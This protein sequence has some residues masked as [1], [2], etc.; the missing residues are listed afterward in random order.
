MTKNFASLLQIEN[1]RELIEYICPN[2]RI[3]VWALIRVSFMRTIMSDW[4]FNSVPMWS[5][6]ENLNYMKMAKNVVIS[7]IHNYGYQI[8]YERKIL[9]Q[10][11]GIGNYTKNGIVHD[12]LAGYFAEILPKQTLVYQDKPKENFQDKYSFNPV[13][14]N[15]P[16]NIINKLYSK[17]AIKS[18]QRNLACSVVE[19][20]AEN[21]FFRLG[22]KFSSNK[23]LNLSNALAGQ[24]ALLPYSSD[25]YANWFSKQR[26]R[27]LLKED[28]CYGG[29]G[30]SIMHA[31]RLNGMVIAEY[32]H[33]AILKGHDAYNVDNTLA[34]CEGFRNVLPDYLLTYGDWWS[35][36]TNMPVKKITIGNPHLTESLIKSNL[37]VNKKNQILVL[38]DGIDTKLLLN[39]SSKILEIVKSKGMTVVFRPHPFERNKVKLQ[40]MPKGVQLDTNSD[41]YQSMRESRVL[42]AEFSTGLFEAVG[43]V[44]KI[45]IWETEKAKFA[46]VEIPFKSFTTMDE[47]EFILYNSIEEKNELKNIKNSELWEPNWKQN[48]INFIEGVIDIKQSAS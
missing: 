43:L 31:A 2:T 44:D 37:V 9:I 19:R 15:N 10:S 24:L 34:E 39:L 27:L 22:Y 4:L 3:P 23:I 17:I 21:A 45:L 35:K 46:F 33:G 36:Q 11:T 18:S 20:A 14:H 1:D 8:N 12:R 13:L 42:I 48:Y 6:N 32:Q 47:L 40:L 25:A 26:F 38:G 28:A 16:R 7:A 30:I 29:V 5:V 41:I